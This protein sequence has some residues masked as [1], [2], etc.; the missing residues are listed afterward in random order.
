MNYA[1]EP[2]RKYADFDGRA[3]RKEFWYYIVFITIVGFI[4]GLIE[5]MLGLFPDQEE[6][7]F[8]LILNV[9]VI[10]PSLAVGVR[11]VHDL[12]KNGWFSIIPFYNLYLF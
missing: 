2:L 12:N 10:V 5:G 8:G 1:V 9:L 3:G 4:L 11:R 6:S 7:V